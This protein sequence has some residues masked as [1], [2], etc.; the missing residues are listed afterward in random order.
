MF[1]IASTACIKGFA[2]LYAAFTGQLKG[3]E[4]PHIVALIFAL[5]VYCYAAFIFYNEMVT[6]D[7]KHDNKSTP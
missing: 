1:C 4:T 3:V 2:L 7:E 5:C 6:K